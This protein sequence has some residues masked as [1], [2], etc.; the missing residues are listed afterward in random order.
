[1]SGSYQL[2]SAM[3]PACRMATGTRAPGRP[4]RMRGRLPVA[5]AHGRPVDEG[6]AVGDPAGRSGYGQYRDEYEEEDKCHGTRVPR[7]RSLVQWQDCPTSGIICPTGV[8][9]TPVAAIAVE[10]IAAVGAGG[11]G[12]GVRPR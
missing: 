12:R 9:L 8:M 3:A 4:S 11:V 6:A 10:N 7:G 1:M 5:V 2:P